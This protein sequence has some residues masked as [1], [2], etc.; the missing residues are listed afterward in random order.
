MIHPVAVGQRVQDGGLVDHFRLRHYV[1]T[2]RFLTGA[3]YRTHQ[4]VLVQL[5]CGER[6]DG[7]CAHRDCILISLQ[8]EPSWFSVSN[9]ARP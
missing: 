3:R 7:Q 6:L 1:A 4:A 2:E 5:E 8:A 9:F